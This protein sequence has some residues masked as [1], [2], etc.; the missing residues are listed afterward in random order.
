SPFD[1]PLET[2]VNDS[3]Y[4]SA[5]TQNWDL[6]L[7]HQLALNTRLRVAYV[8]TK[9]T[10]L[11]GEYDENAPIYDPKLTLSQNRDTID[12]RRPFVG[13]SRILR[14]FH[15]LNSNYNGLQ[16]SFDKRYSSGVTVLASYTWSKAMD[17]QSSN[18]A[19]Q[20]APSSY[21]FNFF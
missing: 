21:P 8:G 12:D 16:V 11:K 19:A 6:A 20:D 13:Y 7:E 2:I 10:H 17:Y 3:K 18:Q 4:L 15:G 14:F 9:A 1:S 5:Y